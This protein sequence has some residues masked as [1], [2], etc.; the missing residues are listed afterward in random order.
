MC[1]VLFVCV[2]G[3]NAEGGIARCSSEIPGVVA[4]RL[5]SKSKQESLTLEEMPPPFH[6]LQNFQRLR[7]EEGW[8]DSTSP[9]VTEYLEEQ[10]PFISNS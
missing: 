9:Q 1:S 8:M 2:Y 6:R 5:A 7:A 3:M 10:S 4:S